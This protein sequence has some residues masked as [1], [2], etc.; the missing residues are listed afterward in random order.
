MARQVHVRDP[1][2]GK[3]ELRAPSLD[4]A[5]EFVE[6]GAGVGFRHGKHHSF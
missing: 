3:T 5:R 1:H 2:V 4:G 6:V